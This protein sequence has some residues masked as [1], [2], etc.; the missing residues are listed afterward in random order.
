ME[1]GSFGQ[2]TSEGSKDSSWERLLE[3]GEWRSWAAVVL[4][5]PRGAVSGAAGG[6]GWGGRQE[7]TL[8]R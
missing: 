8:P 7:V 5:P 4:W 1:G 2:A 6:Q 3:L